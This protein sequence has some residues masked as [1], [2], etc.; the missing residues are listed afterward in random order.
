MKCP[1]CVEKQ[2]KSTVTSLG[3]SVTTAYFPPFYD[4]EGEHHIHDYNTVRQGY[5]CS[6]GHV[7][8]I[9]LDRSPCPNPN[10][11]FGKGEDN[12]SRQN[13]ISYD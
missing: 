7:W 1:V 5:K 13:I 6:K 4:E 9:T 8:G 3:S 10:C 11:N 12:V 2:L